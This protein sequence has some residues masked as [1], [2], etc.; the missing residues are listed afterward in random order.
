MT[1]LANEFFDAVQITGDHSMIPDFTVS[2]RFGDGD[3]NIFGMDIGAQ[4]QY[5]CLRFHMWCVGSALLGSSGRD[6]VSLLEHADRLPP[7][8]PAI[9]MQ[10][11]HHAFFNQTCCASNLLAQVGPQP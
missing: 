3:G 4:I 1:Q 6:F 2:T 10:P 8:Q 9:P 7:K 5:F 11:A